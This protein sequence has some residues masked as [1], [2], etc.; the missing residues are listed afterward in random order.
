MSDLEN[1]KSEEREWNC[2]GIGTPKECVVYFSQLLI[3]LIVVITSIVNLTINSNKTELWV[4]LLSA[5][6]GYIL[7]NPSLSKSK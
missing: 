6:I 3:I 7:P 4:S 2:C 5:C 1:Q